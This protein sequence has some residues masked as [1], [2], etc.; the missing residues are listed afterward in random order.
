MLSC[1]KDFEAV[2]DI[3]VQSLLASKMSKN[4]LM[5]TK[6]WKC[7]SREKQYDATLFLFNINLLWYISQ[8]MSLPVNQG[9]ALHTKIKYT[10]YI[11]IRD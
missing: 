5:I 10:K 1:K 9:I 4:R 11:K 2:K 7:Q 3:Q 6:M 8:E